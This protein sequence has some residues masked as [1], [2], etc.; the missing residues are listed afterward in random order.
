MW[1]NSDTRDRISQK[2]PTHHPRLGVSGVRVLARSCV[3]DYAL[4]PLQSI[5]FLLRR[6]DRPIEREREAEWDPPIPFPSLPMQQPHLPETRPFQSP[7][8]AEFTE[9]NDPTTSES[10]PDQIRTHSS[11]HYSAKRRKRGCVTPCPGSLRRRGRVH[12]TYYSPL[13]GVLYLNTLV[14]LHCGCLVWLEAHMMSPLE[15][16]LRCSRPPLCHITRYY[17]SPPSLALIDFPRA[18]AAALTALIA[19]LA[20][21]HAAPT[22]ALL[23]GC[24]KSNPPSSLLSPSREEPFPTLSPANRGACETKPI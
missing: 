16:A 13:S 22:R 11:P 24:S 1:A 12:A 10:R 17:A 20:R 9:C 18:T 8:V 6:I 3:C 19:L 5:R 15:L 14:A 21:L 7:A 4:W 2:H 23:R